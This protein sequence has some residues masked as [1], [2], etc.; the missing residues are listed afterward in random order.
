M[1]EYRYR[2]VREVLGGSPVGEVAIR[3][4][5]SRQSVHAWRRRFEQDGLTGLVDRSR[6]PVS[7]PNRLVAEVEAAIC[8]M[9]R[10]YPRWGARRIAFELGRDGG[11]APSRATV[12]RVLARNGMVVV[13]EQQHARK[14]RRWQREAPMQLWQL[15]LVG[16]VRLSDGR[17]CKLLT[18]VDDHSR[19]AVIATVVA[20]PSGR[21]V[22]AGFTAAM[23]QH[24]V[25]SEVLTCGRS[26]NS[27]L[28]R[29]LWSACRPGVLCGSW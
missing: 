28:A 16:G 20:V 9:R 24:G 12:H 18:G 3:Y 15:D 29:I 22:C 10:Q 27:V 25:P 4:G 5:T 6:R 2:A 17:E 8:E 19:F 14:Y 26:S 21:A 13:Q 7:S 1:A 23:R 11:R